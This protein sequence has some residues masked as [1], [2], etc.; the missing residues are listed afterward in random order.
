MDPVGDSVRRELRRFG[1]A[2]GMAPVVE[3]WP[4]AVGPE[5]ARNAWPAR[6]AR[7]GT[8]HVHTT[9]SIWAFEL[10][11]RAEEIRGRLGEQA[12]RRLAFAPGPIPEPLETPSEGA[13]TSVPRPGPEHLAKAESLVRVIR[14]E[15]LRKVVAKAAALS[16]AKADNDRSFW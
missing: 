11:S 1:P 7:D 10:K 5:I 8:L 4:A 3:A 14:D 9:D 15:D 13:R 2:A 16:L 6:I 12:P